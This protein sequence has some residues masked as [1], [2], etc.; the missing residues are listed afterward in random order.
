MAFQP[1]STVDA[2]EPA[3][4]LS[5]RRPSAGSAGASAAAA[6]AAADDGACSST[7]AASRVA[8]S[9]EASSASSAFSASSASSASSTAAFSETA[10]SEAASAETASA[11]SSSFSSSASSRISA[12]CTL[13][14]T[15]EFR[16]CAMAVATRS[17]N[18]ISSKDFS[19]IFGISN[20]ATASRGVGSARFSSSG[21]AAAED[22]SPQPA[23]GGRKSTAAAAAA[24]A[25]SVDGGRVLPPPASPFAA[26]TR[27]SN[28]SSS[29]SS[30]GGRFAASGN[31]EGAF[32]V[33]AFPAAFA[34]ARALFARIS[35]SRSRRSASFSETKPSGSAEAIVGAPPAG[36]SSRR[37]RR[38]ASSS[39]SAARRAIWS[40]AVMPPP[41]GAS[42]AAWDERRTFSVPFS[43]PSSFEPFGTR[44]FRVVSPSFVSD[45]RTASAAATAGMFFLRSNPNARASAPPKPPL[46]SSR[47]DAFSFPV[48]ASFSARSPLC[49]L[50]STSSTREASRPSA[51]D[52]LVGSSRTTVGTRRGKFA[53]NE[54]VSAGVGEESIPT[55]VFRE[56]ARAFS[57]PGP[58]GLSVRRGGRFEPTPRGGSGSRSDSARFARSPTSSSNGGGFPDQDSRAFQSVL[59]APRAGAGAGLVGA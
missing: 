14:A 31:E 26:R 2:Y 41:R 52:A 36:A 16:D 42:G 20:S 56:A 13:S 37:A 47:R 35:R 32:F 46:A 3:S 50:S 55:V 59:I 39:L 53:A 30:R 43:V 29:S 7:G 40:D 11:A 23:T 10:S 51:D 9:A 5:S 44:E 34:A 27:A 49:A 25:A 54:D 48:R 1:S 58:P 12:F 21:G 4:S 33:R 18:D 57:S 38:A 28:A 17:S 22:G 19:G 8:S 45:R 6:A 24:A 15:P